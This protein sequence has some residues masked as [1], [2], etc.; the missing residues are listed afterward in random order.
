MYKEEVELDEEKQNYV[1]SDRDAH[2][3]NAS[4]EILNRLKIWTQ[5]MR[6]LKRTII[7]MKENLTKR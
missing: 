1:S 3:M 6:I 5:L 7:P 4:G 2:V